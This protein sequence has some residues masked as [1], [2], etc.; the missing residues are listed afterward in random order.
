MPEQLPEALVRAFAADPRPVRPLPPPWRRALA[1]TPF[2]AA[3]VVAAPGFWGW[4]S[5]LAELGAGMAW[6]L[7]AV[8][9]LLGV[10]VIGA[11]LRE[12][13]PGRNLTRSATLATVG[14]VAALFATVTLATA[15]RAP[16]AV[17]PGRHARWIIE[18][19]GMAL[20]TAVPVLAAAGW[21][22]A[23]ALP[24]RPALA[25]S[26]CGL[27][28]GLL[29]DSGVRLFCWVSDPLHVFVSHGGAVVLLA[30]LGA[31]AAVATDRLRPRAAARAR[32]SGR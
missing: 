18:C 8:Q 30:A 31:A 32:S 25:G 2:G 9:G 14:L 17:P 20:A 27:G 28:A 16:M 23:R 13:V 29:A 4:R 12:A 24:T 5:N 21:L 15:A 10:L 1:L 26:L 22:A 11:A 3:V 6:G 19:L 7:T